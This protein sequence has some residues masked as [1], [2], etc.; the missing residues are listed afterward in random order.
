MGLPSEDD[1][2]A[3]SQDFSDSS[4]DD[5]A[6]HSSETAAILLR[7]CRFPAG[8]FRLRRT[9]R[10]DG[11]IVT[12]IDR[13][14]CYRYRYRDRRYYPGGSCLRLCRTIGSFCRPGQPGGVAAVFV[15]TTACSTGV[16]VWVTALKQQGPTPIARFSAYPRG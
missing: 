2:D 10:R 3:D 6:S 16:S 1:E 14:H 8:N 7:D 4:D 15:G 9:H 11:P 12:R 5:G 13:L